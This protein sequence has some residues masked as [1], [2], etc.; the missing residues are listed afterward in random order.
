[1]LECVGLFLVHSFVQ[2]LDK[3][4][5]STCC[6]LST[7][8]GSWWSAV[9]KKDRDTSPLP[10]RSLHFIWTM[11]LCRLLMFTTSFNKYNTP[12]S[13][14]APNF[15]K[16]TSLQFLIFLFLESLTSVVFSNIGYQQW[17]GALLGML[18]NIEERTSF[19]VSENF[20]GLNLSSVMSWVDLCIFCVS[21][22][23]I[24]KWEEC[25]SC[26]GLSRTCVV[27][28]ISWEIW[29]LYLNPD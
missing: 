20:L 22:S 7:A 3:Y 15:V 8:W 1:M 28:R 24:A 6:R 14:P 4:L 10:W 13:L 23:F 16:Q 11:N 26:S 12:L 9:R 21:N 29:L 25:L 27:L 17:F 18:C 5:F 2:P 19:L